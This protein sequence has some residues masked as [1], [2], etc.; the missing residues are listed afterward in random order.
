MYMKNFRIKLLALLFLGSLFEFSG[1][2]QG[3]DSA[4]AENQAGEYQPLL[5]DG[6]QWVAVH[7]T[8]GNSHLYS[9]HQVITVTVDGE[10]TIEGIV[11]KRLHIKCEHPVKEGES[12]E[13]S[14]CCG[15]PEGESEIYAYEKDKRIYIYRNPGPYYEEGVDMYGQKVNWLKYGDPYFDLYM[16]QN[17]KMGENAPGFGMITKEEYKDYGGFMCREIYTDLDKSWTEGIGSYALHSM[18]E[19][20]RDPYDYV[21]T[22]PY[23]HNMVSCTVNGTTLYDHSE[24]MRSAGIYIGDFT[25]DVR[26][27]EIC[28]DDKSEVLYNLQ[29][30]KVKE[31]RKGEIYI[32]D[33]KKIIF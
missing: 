9:T 10:E 25:S 23:Y 27:A 15:V 12:N 19:I 26:E 29:G 24:S 6:K 18:Y 21:Y 31:P 28:A 1:A 20:Y 3:L 22:R 2:A 33:G 32:R 30:M 17:Y 5:V 14:L 8:T 16:D 13:C 4:T 7:F 11:C